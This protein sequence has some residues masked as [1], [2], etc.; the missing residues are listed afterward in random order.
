MS[1]KQPIKYMFT[2]QVWT[3][4]TPT[5]HHFQFVLTQALKS[6]DCYSLL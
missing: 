3:Q 2:T 5:I 4:E 1:K 6:M